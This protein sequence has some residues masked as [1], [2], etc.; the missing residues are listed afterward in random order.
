[1]QC[2]ALSVSTVSTLSICLGFLSATELSSVVMLISACNTEGFTRQR[3]CYLKSNH[4]YYL[5]EGRGEES[6]NAILCVCLMF[7]GTQLLWQPLGQHICLRLSALVLLHLTTQVLIFF[8]I[9]T[10]DCSGFFVCL[11]VFLEFVFLIS[12]TGSFKILLRIK[13]FW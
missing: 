9:V 4:L 1:M 12:L 11:T 13:L 2:A 3:L 8:L 10:H 7:A 6:R 5:N